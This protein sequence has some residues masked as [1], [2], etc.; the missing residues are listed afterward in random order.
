MWRPSPPGVDEMKDRFRLVGLIALGLLIVA[1]LVWL[2]ILDERDFAERCGAI[3][4]HVAHQ[5][6]TVTS[7]DAKGRPI[8]GSIDHRMCVGPDHREIIP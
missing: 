7:Y 6:N 2:S 3:G 8:F 5:S 1:A 4:G